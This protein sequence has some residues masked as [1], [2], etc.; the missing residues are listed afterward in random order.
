MADCVMVAMLSRSVVASL[1]CLSETAGPVFSCLA[2][3]VDVS[4]C[5]EVDVTGTG[6]PVLGVARQR[7]AAEGN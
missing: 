4:V 2:L 6:E 3:D 1:F 7:Q 5:S